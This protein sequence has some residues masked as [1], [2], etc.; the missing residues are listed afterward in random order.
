MKKFLY[1]LSTLLIGS[2]FT[3]CGQNNSATDTTSNSQN[4]ST[5]PSSAV[6]DTATFGA[7]CFWCVEAQFELL[8]GVVSI[9]SGFSGGTVKNPAYREVCDGLTGHAEVCNIVYDTTKISY[10]ELLEAFWKAHD[11]TQLNRQGNDVGTQYRS[12]I[13]YLNDEQKN[14]AGNVINLAI[15]SGVFKKPIVT[16]VSKAGKFWAAEDYHQ[17]YLNKN[18]YGYTCHHVREDWKF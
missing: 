14:I 5:M 16:K 2:A 4:K 15:A 1:L 8:D 18:P 3:A 11:P 10:D 13:F 7:G 12:E 9:T 17:D 6:L